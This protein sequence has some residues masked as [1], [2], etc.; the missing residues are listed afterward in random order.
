MLNIFYGRESIDKEKFIYER[1]AE[2]HN[3]GRQQRTLVIVPDQYT[4]EAEKQAFRLLHTKSMMDTEITG[5][6]RLGS[7]LIEKQGGGRRTFIDKYGR[8]MLL[9]QIG[10]RLEDKLKVFRGSLRKGSFIE[11]TNNFISEMK[12]YNVK[13]DDLEALRENLEPDSLLA[14][15]LSDLQLLYAEYQQAIEGKYTDSEDYI[16]LYMGKI[17]SSEWIAQ[18]SIWVYGFDS[19]AP[20]AMEVLGNLMASAREVN[21]FLTCDRNC[22]DEELFA[23]PEIVMSNLCRKAEAFDV[24]YKCRKVEQGSGFDCKKNNPAISHL[25]RELYAV[26]KTPFVGEEISGAGEF[27]GEESRITLVQAA[28]LYSEAESAASYILHLLRDKGL[29][30]RDIAVIC[31]DQNVRGSIISRVFEEYGLPLFD[32]RKRNILSSPIAVFVV[33]FLET[34]VCGYRTSDVLTTLKTGFFDL[35]EQEIEQLENYAVKYRIRGTMWKKPFVKGALE[36]G[37]DGLSEIEN[38]RKRAIELFS[39]LE[40]LCCSA[41]TMGSFVAAYYDFLIDKVRLDEKITGLMKEQ[42]N[43]GFL[44]LAEETSQIFGQIV[45]IFDQIAEICGDESFEGGTFLELLSAGLSQMEVG[46][47]PPTSDDV[48]MGTMQRTRSGPVKAVVV[49]GANEGILPAG[50]AP[51]GLFSMEELDFFASEGKEI[52]KVDGIRVMEEQL[53]IYRNLS[54]ASDYLWISF[55]AGDEEGKEIRPSE[56]VDLLQRIYPGLQVKA[57]VVSRDEITELIGGRINTLRHLTE[58]LHLGRKGEKIDGGWKTVAEWYKERDPEKLDE[59]TSAMSFTN[60]QEN[61]PGELAEALYRKELHLP[62]VLSPS[63]LEKFSRCP[64]AHFVAYGLHPLERRIFEAGSREIGD[65]Y[66]HCLMELSQKLSK[67]DTWHTVSE[68][69]CRRMVSEI[70]EREADSYREGLF[71]FGNEERY[72]TGRIADTCFHVCWALIEQV[73]AGQIEESLYEVPFGRNR[74]IAP[75]EVFAEG[76]KVYIEGKIDR[77]DILADN[78]IKIIDYK[79]GQESFRVEE[80]RGGYR[81]QLMLY[82]KAAQENVRKPAGVFYF[83]IGDPRVDLTGI[84][85]EKIFEK[86]SK[87]MKTTFRLDGIMVNDGQIIDGIAGEFEGYSDIVPLRVTK[88]GIKATSDGFL[89]SEEEFAQLQS[90]I[91]RQIEKLCGQLADG[92]IEIRPKKT[93]R[94]SPCTY[95]E[96]KAICRFDIA[97]PGCNYEMIR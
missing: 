60:K 90:D 29:R 43:R 70:A 16:D 20:K 94:E 92:R 65:I 38:I 91:D 54:K 21:V 46:V 61:L 68:E 44:D 32:D 52:C 48:L 96:Y 24:P 6:A 36:Y 1:I 51:E 13:P 62:L 79:T 76:E 7:R 8:H 57:D 26:T 50:R 83:K 18:S 28:N 87:E 59:I 40:K 81:L 30:C 53:A 69:E 95:C 66:H 82:L 22:R 80:A 67:E 86:I 37:D 73:R 2:E 77:L 89:L 72:K 9:T 39:E 45:A 14:A 47:L 49:I 55:S 10:T 75:V 88:D 71:R 33:S 97:F 19:F 78:R 63:R 56:I 34:A 17:K 93:D 3:A 84:A 85:R 41:D 35:T 5:M 64:F 27:P 31:N 11:M 74:N 42:E 15:K 12:Q 58:A 4:L 25:E 23:L